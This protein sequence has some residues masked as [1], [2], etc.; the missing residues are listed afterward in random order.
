MKR[1]LFVSLL[2]ALLSFLAMAQNTEK[3]S[4]PDGNEWL[5][6]MRSEK[7]AFLTAEMELTPE[8][9]QVFWPVYNEYQ[10]QMF[11]ATKAS[12]ESFMALDKSVS[13]KFGDKEIEKLISQYIEADASRIA[14]AKKYLPEFY[15]VLPAEKVARLY[16]GEEKF[17][18]SRIHR[19]RECKEDVPKG[20]E[21][22]KRRGT[23]GNPGGPSMEMRMLD[24]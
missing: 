1:V 10:A 9:A 5:Q 13:S 11:A 21:A 15:K 2:L 6:R 16:I 17:R 14:V 8:E 22:K 20:N 24:E 23:P 19:L 4:C 12:R 3:P 18:M 7:I